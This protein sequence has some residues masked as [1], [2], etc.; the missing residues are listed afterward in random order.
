M[1]THTHTHT[2]TLNMVDTEAT[3]LLDNSE[4]DDE[5]E[6]EKIDYKQMVWFHGKASIVHVMY[7]LEL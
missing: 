4:E 7:S 5:V 2:R 1:Y 6:A 3:P